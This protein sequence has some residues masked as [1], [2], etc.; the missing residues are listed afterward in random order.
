MPQPMYLTIIKKLEKQSIMRNFQ[1]TS[2]SHSV[3][4]TDLEMTIAAFSELFHSVGGKHQRNMQFNMICEA[5]R[6]GM[7]EE[8]AKEYKIIDKLNF[9][10]F[11]AGDKNLLPRQSSLL[12]MLTEKRIGPLIRES[13]SKDIP[14]V[15]FV[16]ESVSEYVTQ[17]CGL[18]IKPAV[19]GFCVETVTNALRMLY[20]D[21]EAL[22]LFQRSAKI[23]Y[24]EISGRIS[25]KRAALAY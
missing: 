15:S 18:F 16:N 7:V 5:D 12:L 1:V 10:D 6:K 19:F 20:F 14:V 9:I 11:V 22:M 25:T 4:D 23:R 3:S 13:L 21:P 24:F 2:S 8:F 17:K